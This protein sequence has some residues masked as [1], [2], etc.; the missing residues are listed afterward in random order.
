MLLA[1]VV[2]SALLG[3]ARAQMPLPPPHGHAAGATAP[4]TAPL[5]H[6]RFVG[7]RGMQITVYSGGPEARAF[8]QS[9]V[10]GLRPGYVYRFK[11]G[12][13]AER[14][15]VTLYP[16]LE[17]RGTLQLPPE[18]SASAYPAPV[19]L[20]LE[21]I[22]RA[23]AGALVTKV[24]YLE[25]VEHARG[26]ATRPDLPLETELGPAEDLLEEARLLGRPVLVVRLGG[27]IFSDQELVAE[28]VAGTI[29]LPGEKALARP[30]V[31]PV[32]PAPCFAVSD[33]CRGPRLSEA[34]CMCDGGDIGWPAGLDAMGRL[35]GLD[36]SDTV[37][38]YTDNHG[39]RHLAI[40]NRICLCAPRY[41]VLRTQSA[42]LGLQ[43]A[44]IP[45]RTEAALG[46]SLLQIRQPPLET[47]QPEQLALVQSRERPSSVRQ[48]IALAIAEQLRGPVALVGRIQE[49]TITGVL[50]EHKPLPPERPLVLE[51]W[52]DKQAGQIGDIVT[53]TLRY[54]NR[55]GQPISDVGISDSLVS[56][57]EY[58]VGSAKWDRPAVFTLQEN[59]A[60]SAVLRWQISGQLL[61]GQSGLVQFQVRIR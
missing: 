9:A 29:L 8:D 30:L 54:S 48:A 26:A 52:S 19:L 51:K 11:V 4:A 6:V 60:G 27:R 13:I 28:A 1:V 50:E 46:Q 33:P 57:L 22:D 47:K 35:R 16:S 36:P 2:G 56:R 45:G 41:A 31:P 39:G 14:P 38:V 37:A 58:V 42:P 23:R 59:E 24:I 49:R 55:G 7:A 34:E 20:T 12:D 32:L 10:F 18:M 53:F 61:P 17:V 43:V 3:E 40:S 21:D 25:S 44:E 5:L 15:G